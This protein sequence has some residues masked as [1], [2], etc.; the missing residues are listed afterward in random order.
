M[1]IAEREIRFI[2]NSIIIFF[3]NHLKIRELIVIIDWCL[4]EMISVCRLRIN[5]LWVIFNW[6]IE[7]LISIRVLS[8]LDC[9][10]RSSKHW[11]N[12]FSMNNSLDLTDSKSSSFRIISRIH[13]CPLRPIISHLW[14]ANLRLFIIKY[15]FLSGPSLTASYRRYKKTLLTC[16]LLWVVA[17]LRFQIKLDMP[18]SHLLL[19]CA[20][21]MRVLQIIF[22]LLLISSLLHLLMIQK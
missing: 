12:L 14:W 16:I 15:S 19:G 1:V 18:L 3:L 17:Y 6:F 4:W 22:N 10:L 11:T 7:H 20:L 5:G 21:W 8:F 13:Y 9:M 2:V